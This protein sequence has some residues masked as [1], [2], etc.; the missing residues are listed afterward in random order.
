MLAL[1]CRR[2]DA[3]QRHTRACQRGEAADV[4]SFA[5]G[6]HAA[7]HHGLVAL[8]PATAAAQANSSIPA[9]G[10]DGSRW[11]NLSG[12]PVPLWTLGMP[13]S[14]TLQPRTHID[15]MYFNSDGTIR[16]LARTL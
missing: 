9:H 8:R 1:T 13:Y 11:N 15:H 3:G 12:A 4:Q 6:D 2:V 7:R 14:Q 10:N 5:K 16:T